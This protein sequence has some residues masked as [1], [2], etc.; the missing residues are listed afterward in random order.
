MIEFAVTRMLEDSCRCIG[1]LKTRY[2]RRDIP[3]G[4]SMNEFAVPKNGKI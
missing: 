3:N 1:V 4:Y 2:Q